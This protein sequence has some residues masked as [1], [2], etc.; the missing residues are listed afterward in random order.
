[1]NP[2]AGGYKNITATGVVTSKPGWMLGFYVNN[3]S[4]G[5]IVFRDGG[6]SGTVMTGTIT[7]AIGWN[8]FP[9]AFATGLHATI[10][11][12]LDTTIVFVSG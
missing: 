1:M 8:N 3:T 4:S 6:A 2:N 11:S 7:P 12:T 9:V 10:A 5:T